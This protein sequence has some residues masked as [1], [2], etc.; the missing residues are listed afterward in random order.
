MHH[1]LHAKFAHSEQTVQLQRVT[2]RLQQAL[3]DPAQAG[4][5]QHSIHLHN[6]LHA[7]YPA[8]C[9][10]LAEGLPAGSAVHC[11]QT[12][13]AITTSSHCHL[14]LLLLHHTMKSRTQLTVLLSYA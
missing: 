9:Q 5:L 10:A 7:R 11:A 1:A 14:L 4:S 2:L 8:A 13:L 6:R 12:L 3:A